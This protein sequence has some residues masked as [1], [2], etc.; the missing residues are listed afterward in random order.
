MGDN[1]R[2]LVVGSCSKRKLIQ[3]KDAPSCNDLSTKDA[4]FKWQELLCDYVVSARE[5]Y[6]GYLNQELTKGVD[7]LRAI[8]GLEVQLVIVSAGFGIIGENELIPPYDCSFSGMRKRE[9]H[10]RKND[11]MI[12][13]DFARICSSGFDIVYLALGRNYLL[14]LG[15]EWKSVTTS[16]VVGFD[17]NLAGPRAVCIPSGY[18]TV[19]TFSSQGH[20][21]HGVVGFKGDL[22]RIL[23]QFATE[24]DVPFYEVMRWRNHD[25]LQNLIQRLGGL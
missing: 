25:Y 17:K 2:I 18:R 10:T 16:I 4:L 20:I 21:I 5:M 11:L 3:H 12:E 6:R 19:S 8:E 22:L 7:L 14:A 23:A 9:I 1:L 13:Y 24:H 15:D